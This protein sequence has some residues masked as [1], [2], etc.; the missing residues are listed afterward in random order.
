[1]P[2]GAFRE[3]GEDTLDFRGILNAAAKA[4]VEHYF[5]E[6]D[7]SRGDPMDSV[8]RC[9]EYLKGLAL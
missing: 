3:L 7:F 5:V 1:M 4:G 2:P 6:L 9:V 8:R